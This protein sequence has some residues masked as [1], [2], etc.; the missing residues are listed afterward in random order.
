MNFE[1]W[2]M[3]SELAVYDSVLEPWDYRS[4]DKWAREED[5]DAYLN[6]DEWLDDEYDFK[7]H[8]EHMKELVDQAVE[9]VRT[10]LLKFEPLLLDYWVNAQT[11]LNLL[12]NERLANPTDVLPLLLERFFAQ[13][14]MY[15][16]YI[17]VEKALGLL[18]VKFQ[19]V[20]D[21]LV[22][23]PRGIIAEI[24][25]ELPLNLIK[26]VSFCLTWMNKYVVELKLQPDHVD[27]FVTQI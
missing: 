26:R 24:K 11:D 9:K 12:T 20:K 1:K 19:Q 8:E 3:H 22:V 6:C 27:K 21:A 25:K 17:P 18:N 5:E 14:K 23:S 13:K 7:F 2:S 16:T 4:Y 15:E 10:Q